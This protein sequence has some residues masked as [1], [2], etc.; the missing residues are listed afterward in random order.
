MVQ[1]DM[2]KQAKGRIAPF[3]VQWQDIIEEEVTSTFI[4]EDV[5]FTFAMFRLKCLLL[6]S[7]VMA[8]IPTLNIGGLNEVLLK[9]MGTWLYVHK[10]FALFKKNCM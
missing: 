1:Y 4:N 2:I 10:Q 8:L 9:S 6:S 3:K 7:G 5:L